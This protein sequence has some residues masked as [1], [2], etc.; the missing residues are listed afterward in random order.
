[1]ADKKF[2]CGKPVENDSSHPVVGGDFLENLGKNQTGVEITENQ[3]K[4]LLKEKMNIDYDKITINADE[5][6]RAKFTAELLF[7]DNGLTM[8]ERKAI[9]PVA[10]KFFKKP[11]DAD[12]YLTVMERALNDETWWKRG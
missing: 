6:L 3:I 12:V 2:N 10:M 1:M 8:N 5:S 11:S 4:F 9:L 7:L